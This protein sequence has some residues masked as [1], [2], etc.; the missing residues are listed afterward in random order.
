MIAL[1][2]LLL[3]EP[4]A[5]NCEG[6][7]ETIAA[8][9]VRG[10]HVMLLG[11]TMEDPPNPVYSERAPVTGVTVDASFSL[12]GSALGSGDVAWWDDVVAL[13]EAGNRS[14]GCP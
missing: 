6:G 9:Q 12:S 4:V 5:L 7:P 3:W 13:D 1:L 2:V 14:D 11:W 10:Q 8:Y